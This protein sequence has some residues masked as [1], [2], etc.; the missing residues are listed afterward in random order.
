MEINTAVAAFSAL[1]H[2]G[3]LSIY[4]LLVEAGADGLPVG[5]IAA[6][7]D[8]PGPTLSFHLSRLQRAGLIHTDR[9]GR[10]LIQS[11]D[12]TQMN[13]L[14]GYLTENCC[15]GE[16]CAPVCKPVK[17]GKGRRSGMK[18]QAAAA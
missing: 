7:L 14:I 9:Q 4:R 3:R 17:G 18:R 13:A 8:M 12:F 16:S 11:A 10:R 15:G 5:E 1:A 6:A 2:E